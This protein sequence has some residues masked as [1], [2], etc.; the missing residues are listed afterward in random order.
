M[1]PT[2]NME[3]VEGVPLTQI[4]A[5]NDNLH[6]SSE[7]LAWGY[8]VEWFENGGL[9]SLPSLK[10]LVEFG[11]PPRKGVLPLHTCNKRKDA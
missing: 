4:E 6:A 9:A 8:R 11:G 10:N 3:W 5:P 2:R 7:V 1:H